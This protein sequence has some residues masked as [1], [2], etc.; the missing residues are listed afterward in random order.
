MDPEPTLYESAYYF[1]F[2][3]GL[4]VREFCRAGDNYAGWVG[5][6]A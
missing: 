3:W 4:C 6:L 1:D 2:W 5:A